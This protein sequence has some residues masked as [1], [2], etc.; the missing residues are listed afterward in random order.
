MLW[1]YAT[2]LQENIYTEVWF[3]TLFDLV[4]FATLLKSPFDMGVLLQIFC[5][6]SEHIFLRPSLEG[7]FWR[8][9]TYFGFI[10]LTY[11][12]LLLKYNDSVLIDNFKWKYVTCKLT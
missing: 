3:A 4:C 12:L 9:Y 2:N 11:I 6:F 8:C 1:K 10:I 5:K 7:C